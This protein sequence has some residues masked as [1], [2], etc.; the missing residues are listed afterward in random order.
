[1]AKFGVLETAPAAVPTPSANHQNMFV[2]SADQLLYLKDST[3]TSTAVGA[4][5]SPHPIL[6][7]THNDA[8]TDTVVRGDLMYGNA[9]PNWDR[10]PVST[11][12]VGGDGTDVGYLTSAAA[13]ALLDVAT[14]GLKGLAPASGGGTTNFLRADLTWA[15][16]PD[17]NTQN[18]LD[19]AYDEGGAGVGRFITADSGPV[20]FQG[21]SPG[22]DDLLDVHTLATDI[23][24]CTTDMVSY[25]STR[26]NSAAVSRTDDWDTQS[27]LRTSVMNNAGGDLTVNGALFKAKTVATETLGT[28]TDNTHLYEGELAANGAGQF[29]RFFQTGDAIHRFAVAKDGELFFGD[30]ATLSASLGFGGSNVVDCTNVLNAATGFRVAGAATSGNVLRGNATNFVSATLAAGD[31]SDGVTGSGAV[32]L[33][34]SPTIVTPTVASFANA[35]HNHTNAA[36]GGQV[37][38]STALSD[39]AALALLASTQTFSGDKTFT[40]KFVAPKNKTT[41][42]DGEITID[43]TESQFVYRDSSGEHVLQRFK[44]LGVSI[45][46]PATGKKGGAFFTHM[47]AVT[48]REVTAAR[49]GGTS[50]AFEVRYGTDLNGAGTLAL[51]STV[52]VSTADTDTGLT[53]TVPKDNFIWFETDTVTG[54]V[55]NFFAQASGTYDRA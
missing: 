28:L 43:D 46:D 54:A 41:V 10:L 11:G 1:M 35:T 13:T 39:Y 53:V 4:G 40:G 42:T 48:I 7:A 14:S 24:N 3:G 16:P 30:G 47:G 27:Q 33:A 17:T 55:D 21:F 38:A 49:V 2:S 34:T 20:L 12:L 52:S 50:V 29:L 22:G 51:S 23:T 15:A 18:S 31:L 19:E 6:G 26:T 44:P 25:Y 9:T 32:V 36:G 8:V 45:S 5:G 37:A